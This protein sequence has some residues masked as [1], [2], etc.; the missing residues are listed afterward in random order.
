MK[1][2][3]KLLLWFDMAMTAFAHAMVSFFAM[4]GSLIMKLPWR[5]FYENVI[6]SAPCKLVYRF[7]LRPVLMVFIIMPFK[8]GLWVLRPVVTRLAK[9]LG[10]PIEKI[11]PVQRLMLV[12]RPFWVGDKK[13]TAFT[14]LAI[15]VTLL[16]ANSGAAYLLSVMTRNFNTAVEHKSMVDFLWA[17]GYWICAMAIATPVQVY[18]G[19]FRTKLALIWRPW[20]TTQYFALYFSQQRYLKLLGKTEI[21]N[22]DQRMTQDVDSFCNSAVGLFIAILDATVN[23]CMFASV[24]FFMSGV[25]TMTVVLYAAFGSAMVLWLGKDLP[26]INFNQVKTEADLRSRLQES[27]QNADSLAM[28]RGEEVAKEQAE[29]G[30]NNVMGTLTS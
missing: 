10:P 7:T 13:W 21:D 2:L 18:Y 16:F 25:L 6:K 23:V 28:Y 19:Y 1:F 24:L 29:S 11:F 26:G 8:G 15:I 20:L 30:L 17:T 5:W 27:K 9:W 3:H 12:G 14:H 22:P 4:I